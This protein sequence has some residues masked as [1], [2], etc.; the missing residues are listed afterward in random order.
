MSLL[1]I[2]QADFSAIRS[3]TSDVDGNLTENGKFSSDFILPLLDLQSARIKALL[4]T[5]RSTILNPLFRSNA[6]QL[7]LCFSKVPRRIWDL[8]VHWLP[9]FRS[10]SVMW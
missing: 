5:D 6:T 8:L 2:N 7:P 1:P 4:V 3:T 9:N 10:V